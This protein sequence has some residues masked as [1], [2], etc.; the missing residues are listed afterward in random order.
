VLGVVCARCC[1]E[2]KI[3]QGLVAPHLENKLYIG[4]LTRGH[5]YRFY[6]ALST[7][8]TSLR[9]RLHEEY[10]KSGRV[11]EVE[12]VE[13]SATPLKSPFEDAL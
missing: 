2:F 5:P 1:A 4:F 12:A 9:S 10:I 13:G 7:E 8:M 3:E 11:A 6:Q